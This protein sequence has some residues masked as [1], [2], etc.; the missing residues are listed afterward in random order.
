[1]NYINSNS[2]LKILNIYRQ[3]INPQIRVM[4]LLM[5][6]HINH[7]KYLIKITLT[8]NQLEYNKY[9]VNLN[10]NNKIVLIINFIII[11]T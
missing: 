3:K 5:T 6:I 1:M 10:H 7:R 2:N 11:T 4:N 8:K 9:K